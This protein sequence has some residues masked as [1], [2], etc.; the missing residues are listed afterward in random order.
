MII[1]SLISDSFVGSINPNWYINALSLGNHDSSSDNKELVGDYGS[2][3]SHKKDSF[4]AP[5][6]VCHFGFQNKA[7][8]KKSQDKA[9]SA[10][11]RINGSISLPI[12]CAVKGMTYFQLVFGDPGQAWWLNAEYLQE[13]V[14]HG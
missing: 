8:M 7:K 10:A 11:T 9:V 6:L 13:K 4:E 1:V 5:K 2:N 14:Q 12:K 3:V